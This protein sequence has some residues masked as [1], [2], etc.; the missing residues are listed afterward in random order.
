MLLHR[1]R[2][3]TPLCARFGPPLCGRPERRRGKGSQ[4]SSTLLGAP[5]ERLAR[6]FSYASAPPSLPLRL[7]GRS[8]SLA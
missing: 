5:V 1:N 6:S 4:Q 7:S 2:R 3:A 8:R